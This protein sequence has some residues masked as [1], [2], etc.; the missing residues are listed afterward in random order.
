MN[1]ENTRIVKDLVKKKGF[2]TNLHFRRTLTAA[3]ETKNNVSWREEK[4][5]TPGILARHFGF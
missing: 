4:Q 2:N 1:A 3:Q 5:S